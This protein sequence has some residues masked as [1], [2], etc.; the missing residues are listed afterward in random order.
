MCFIMTVNY[1]QVL[2]LVRDFVEAAGY[3]HSHLNLFHV[4]LLLFMLTISPLCPQL[5]VIYRCYCYL[6]D[7]A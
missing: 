1:D 4:L 5:I 3:A 2:V 6:D 7:P